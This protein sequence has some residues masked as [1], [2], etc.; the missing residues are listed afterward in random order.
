[1]S[2]VAPL[3]PGIDI[4]GLSDDENRVLQWL[5]QRLNGVR[6]ELLLS[7]SYYE[8]LQQVTN[9]GI[10]M[11]PE[12]DGLRAVLGWPQS[13]VDALDER[14]DLQGFRLPGITTADADLWAIWEENNLSAESK[15]VH[16]D[17]LIYGAAYALVGTDDDGDVTITAESPINL[18]AFYDTYARKTTCAY[19]AYV[20]VDPLSPLYSR[21]RAVLYLPGSTIHVVSDGSRWELVERDDHK[22]G[23]VPVVPFLN[24]Q[25]TG[26]R[27]GQSEIT[28]AWRNTVDRASR[29]MVAMEGIREFFGAPKMLVLG[30]TESAFQNNDGSTK[31]AWE[32]YL[33]RVLALEATPEGDIPKVERFA[34]EDPGAI[35]KLIDHE[36]HHMAGL[37]GLPP[38]YLGI[39]SDGNPASADAIRMSDYR[40]QKKADRKAVQFG[41]C[42]EQVMR[43]AVLVR[44][45]ELPDQ[46]NRLES[47]WAPTG[48]P[49]PAADVDATTKLNAAGVLPPT[50]DVQ[51]TRLGYTAN[52]RD[53]IRIERDKA[54]AAT[55]VATLLASRT[56]EPPPDQNAIT[57]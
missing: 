55:A 27:E 42:W 32:T 12:L 20:E 44:D 46:M 3:V 30:A 41:D 56:T 18:V 15:L 1:M 54:S 29:S 5:A 49:T 7:N 38:Q 35:I 2:D 33:G 4:S 28:A 19:Q 16:L 34:G 8:G 47:D 57:G 51:L 37:T 6:G 26:V 39:F 17:S 40:L 36:R 50:S 23:M 53:R 52:E 31:T 9:L 14:L 22:L 10:S 24:R 11:P 13:G 21:Q 48:I 43:L 45:G 25:R